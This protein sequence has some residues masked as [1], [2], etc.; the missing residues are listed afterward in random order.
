MS[1]AP[2]SDREKRVAKPEPHV[3]KGKLPVFD[4]KLLAGVTW[5]RLSQKKF[6]SQFYPSQRSRLTPASWNFPC[7][8]LGANIVTSTTEVI[9]DKLALMKLN[10]R[11]IAVFP[12]K[13]AQ[14]QQYLSVGKFPKLKLCNL[15]DPDTRLGLNFEGGA[16]LT[17]DLSI[18][19]AWAQAI[20]E[21][22]C[23]FDGI[24]YRSRH[25]DVPCVV[26]WNRPGGRQLE[27]ELEFSVLGEFYNSDAA[28]ETGRKMGIRVTF[29]S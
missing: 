15:T 22:K 6:S 29:V 5:V 11:K 14:A 21:H 7:C 16:L 1:A 26:L 19:Q 20:A 24:Y 28:Y 3:I 8:Y 18:P 13:E 12:K 9:G 17:P 2:A 4:E 25:T 10:K 27:R 23:E